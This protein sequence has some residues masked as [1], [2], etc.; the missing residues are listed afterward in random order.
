MPSPTVLATAVLMAVMTIQ[1]AGAADAATPADTAASAPAAEA[2]QPGGDTQVDTVVIT[3][4]TR[5]EGLRKLEASYSITTAD[6][7]QI[8]QAAP[9]STADLLKIVPGVYVETTGG[10]TG[11][12][13]RVRGFPT[14]GDGPYSTIDLNGA[15][16]YPLPTLSFFEHSSI[17]RLDD[18]IDHVEVLR[19]GPSPI[20]G[21]GQPGVTVNFIQKKG[22]DTPEGSLRLTTGTGDERRV[23]AVLS[24]KLADHWTA[25]VG[26]FYRSDYSVRNTEYPADRGG[27][28]SVMLTRK[29][30]DGEVDFYGRAMNE[31]N[32][33][34][35]PIPLVGSADGSSVS[36]LPYF[37]AHTAT[38]YGNELRNISLE[39]GFMGGDGKIQQQSVQRDVAN[40]RGANVTTLGM[41]L[42]KKLGAWTL[43]NKLNYTSGDV[44]TYALFTGA[45]PTTI[46]SYIAAQM[47]AANADAGVLAAAGT[48]ATAGT[49]KYVDNGSAITDMNTP[50]IVNGLWVVDKHLQSFTNETRLNYDLTKDN[51][52]SLG[53]YLADY[54]SHDQWYLGEAYLMSVQAH[55]R[56]ISVALDNGVMVTR[57]DGLAPPQFTYDID[58]SYNGTTTAAYVAD[59]WKL[60]DQ[61]RIDGGIRFERQRMSGTLATA[62]SG[63]LDAN[64]LTLY[65]NTLGYFDGASAPLVPGG[66]QTLNATSATLG[67]NYNF[68]HE[69]SVF[70]RLN[71]GHRMPDFDVMR[72][73]G[74]ADTSSPIEDI[75]QAELGLKTAT[76]LYTAFL[77]FFHNELKNSQTYSFALGNGAQSQRASSRATGVE[78]E[79]SLRP[80]KGLELGLTGTYQDAKYQ[81]FGQ[82]SGN[83]VERTPKVQYR[84]TPSYRIPTDFATFQV[85]GTWS[86]VGSR[87]L[88]QTNAQKIPS[89]NTLDAGIVAQF[90]NGI[91]VRLTGTNLNNSLGITEGNPR[92]VGNSQDTNGV[93]LGRPLFGRAY[94][95]SV[96]FLF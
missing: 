90:D 63:D 15:P 82:Y 27:Q 88:D 67:A 84:F 72:G 35:T 85:F 37:D 29:L 40:G 61:L 28:L 73:R 32:A 58:G 39:T 20:F 87:Y 46:G 47:A 79:A 86:Y 22:G 94:E 41:N 36:S 17:F 60:S 52:L 45:N 2:A 44:P 64:P 6:E 1:R 62:K 56:P 3:G 70:G 25:M 77:T 80:L 19:G 24:G 57:A 34:F 78:F 42:D 8:K 68:T 38:F 71:Q 83:V 91:E 48:A 43:S 95:L 5:R 23:D 81:D 55:A 11:A 33:F 93:F 54:S 12:N 16:L 75:S 76:K 66:T 14:P 74:L 18:T 89:Y 51:T 31:K 30:D 96:G 21:A 92:V 7:E 26:G 10:Q 65:N 50:V 59:D 69:F 13:I 53:L 9:S 49:A 4:T